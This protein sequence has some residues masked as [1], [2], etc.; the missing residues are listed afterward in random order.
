MQSIPALAS[1]WKRLCAS[2]LDTIIIMIP[3]FPC[4]MLTGYLSRSMSQ[5]LSLGDRL[6]AGAFGWILYLAINFLP[7]SRSGQTQGKKLMKIQIVD[8]EGQIPA[9]AKLVIMRNFLPGILFQIPYIGGLLGL[10][11]CLS[12]FTADR[13]CLHDHL[14]GTYVVDAVGAGSYDYVQTNQSEI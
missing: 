10:V 5:S 8:T 1:R 11:D 4:L 13:R 2:L 9:I 7:L 3:L 14:A 6:M 12:I